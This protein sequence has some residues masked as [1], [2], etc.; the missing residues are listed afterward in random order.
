MHE[1]REPPERAHDDEAQIG[2]AIE[3]AGERGEQPVHVLARI[4]LADVQDVATGHAEAFACDGGAG[5]TRRRPEALV[6]G[7]GDHANALGRD[8]EASDHI[9]LRRLGDRDDRVSPFRER[10]LPRVA[11]TRV[12]QA[13]VVRW[14]VQRREIVQRQHDRSAAD[15]GQTELHRVVQVALT[16]ELERQQQRVD[17]E[18][19]ELG[20]AQP[21]RRACAMH[22]EM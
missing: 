6:D 11:G 21:V 9:H 4:E 5:L 3:R 22:R 8:A 7:L 1:R 19:R 10:V 20:P 17:R 13:Q 18:H 12:R 14:P 15:R 2:L 16:G